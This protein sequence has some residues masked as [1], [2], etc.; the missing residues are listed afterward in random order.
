MK[1]NKK[2]W[3][4]N[5]SCLVMKHDMWMSSTY[6]LQQ[7]FRYLP[8]SFAFFVCSSVSKVQSFYFPLYFLINICYEYFS[9][10]QQ[11]LV[12]MEPPHSAWFL[13]KIHKKRKKRKKNQTLDDKSDVHWRM[14]FLL[15]T[16][17]LISL[18]FSSSANHVNRYSNFC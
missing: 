17:P 11:N 2:K 10:Q 15:K 16:R 14:K 8:P 3:K 5:K 1:N 18:P 12:V 13:T 4:K 7:T 9:K 6:C